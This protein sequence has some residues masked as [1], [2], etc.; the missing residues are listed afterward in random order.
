MSSDG[1]GTMLLILALA[2]AGLGIVIG[3][4]IGKSEMRGQ[5]CAAFCAPSKVWRVDDQ[6]CLCPDKQLDFTGGAK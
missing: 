3:I 6:V 2:C 5:A 4:M 1:V